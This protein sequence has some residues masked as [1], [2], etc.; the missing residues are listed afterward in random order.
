MSQKGDS[1]SADSCFRRDEAQILFLK[2]T[3]K[4]SRDVQMMGRGTV[5]HTRIVRILDMPTDSKPVITD[6]INLENALG[7]P[8]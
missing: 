1:T 7:T 4:S 6:N 2:P 5:E 3:K 8:A